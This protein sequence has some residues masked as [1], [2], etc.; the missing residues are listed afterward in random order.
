MSWP[1]PSPVSWRWLSPAGWL[2]SLVSWRWPSPV[3]SG[4]HRGPVAHG[5]RLP[6]GLPF[7]RAQ[8]RPTR[9]RLLRHYPRWLR[10][11][12]RDRDDGSW[13]GCRQPVPVR[14]LCRRAR[15]PA[16]PAG[17]TSQLLP[18]A[19][20]GPRRRWPEGATAKQ[21][22]QNISAE[23]SDALVYERPFRTICLNP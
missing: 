12:S 1:L 19:A 5:S 8:L 22:K 4:R 2:P 9:E 15:N 13:R 16:G 10:L 7:P 20:A 3:S 14:P 18:T 11:A 17:R 6:P 21:S 23:T